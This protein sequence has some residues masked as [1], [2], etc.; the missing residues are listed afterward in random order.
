MSHRLRGC[1]PGG[2][3]VW[4]RVDGPRPPTR[5]CDADDTL[6]SPSISLRTMGTGGYP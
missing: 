3:V 6:S 2:D 4:G 1:P 5:Q